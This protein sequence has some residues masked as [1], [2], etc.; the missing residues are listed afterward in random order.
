MNVLH[1]NYYNKEGKRECWDEM[2][3]IFGAK[4]VFIFDVLNA[5]KYCY[6]A[7]EKDGNPREQD[8]S[9]IEN[10]LNHAES[11]KENM[12]EEDMLLIMKDILKKEGIDIEGN[13][14]TND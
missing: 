11:L 2:I 10:Y 3:D 1:Q 12:Y 5:Y 9:K 13:S 4:N 6:R 7:G 8:I 14:D